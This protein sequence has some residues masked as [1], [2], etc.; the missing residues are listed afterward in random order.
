MSTRKI[1]IILN[2]GT[3][4]ALSFYVIKKGLDVVLGIAW[5]LGLLSLALNIYCEVKYGR[6][7][8]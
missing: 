3:I 4:A 7:E 1:L 8:D 5:I 2:I 6:K